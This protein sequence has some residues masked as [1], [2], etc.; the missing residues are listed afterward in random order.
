MRS[1]ANAMIFCIFEIFLFAAS[2][3]AN[4]IIFG[5]LVSTLH[6]VDDLR[7]QLQQRDSLISSLTHHL[8]ELEDGG[9][10]AANMNSRGASQIAREGKDVFTGG[11]SAQLL[12]QRS[13]NNLKTNMRGF[14]A[15]AQHTVGA[16][17]HMRQ[18]A[19][20]TLEERVADVSA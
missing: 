12:L 19:A 6:S 14:Y 2:S 10:P 3:P 20:P 11:Q 9:T 7:L 5:N 17:A 4:L 18:T 8:H 13:A 16:V 15:E 1:Q